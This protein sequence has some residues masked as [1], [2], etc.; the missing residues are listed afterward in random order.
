MSAGA[1]AS[2]PTRSRCRSPS[3]R[4]RSVLRDEVR[5]EEVAEL[6]TTGVVRVPDIDPGV[7]ALPHRQHPEPDELA[8]QLAE[9]RVVTDEARTL[10]VPGLA[11]DRVDG[12]QVQRPAQP[13]VLDDLDLATHR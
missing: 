10:D 8:E 4:R 12:R 11:H 9:V 7:G 6:P 1:R 5:R 3:T 13:R 2:P